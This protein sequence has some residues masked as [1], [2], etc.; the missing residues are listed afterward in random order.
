MHRF[1]LTRNT[2][3]KCTWCRENIG[4]DGKGWRWE[5]CENNPYDPD[6]GYNRTNINVYIE[7]D[8]DAAAF[9]LAWEPEDPNEEVPQY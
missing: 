8:D 5:V 7:N 6:F 1:H 4:P 9:K 3:E 2:G